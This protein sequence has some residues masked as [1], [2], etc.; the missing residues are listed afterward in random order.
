MSGCQFVCH[1]S[2]AKEQIL[3]TEGLLEF[4]CVCV[5]VCVQVFVCVFNVSN[6]TFFVVCFSTLNNLYKCHS[7]TLS[8]HKKKNSLCAQTV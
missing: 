7:L 8:Q 5:Y 6:I 4:I 3:L 1:S 2:A